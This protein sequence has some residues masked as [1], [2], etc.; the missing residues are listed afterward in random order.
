MK[1]N[2]KKLLLLIIA[3]LICLLVFI[4]VEIFAK[5]LSS[6]IGSTSIKIAN[7]NIK[8]NNNSI[9]T[10]TDI[11]S[12]LIPI[13]PG[14]EN[15]APNIIAPTAEGYFDLTIDSSEVDV[16]FR[17]DINLK[18]NPQSSVVDLVVSGYSIDNGPIIKLSDKSNIISD[19]ILLSSSSKSRKLRI[20]V[21][22]NDD[23]STQTMNNIDDTLSTISTTP[24]LL[25]VNISFTQVA[26]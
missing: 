20:Y 7:W 4:S 2:R 3:L 15:I 10:N 9:K 8:V 19:T 1:N 14:N 23:I 5:Y 6:S 12:T 18:V 25:D 16:S 11:S 13:F 21:F 17:Y 22:W 26:Q 24:A